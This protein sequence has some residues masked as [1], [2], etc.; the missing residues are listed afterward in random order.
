M[1][2][3]SNSVVMFDED[4]LENFLWEIKKKVQ[5]AWKAGYQPDAEC[6]MTFTE[7]DTD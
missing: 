4:S 6:E 5:E 1:Q 2:D 3:W 7:D